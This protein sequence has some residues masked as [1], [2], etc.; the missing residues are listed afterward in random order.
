MIE[1]DISPAA[2]VMA[3]CTVRAKLSTMGVIRGMAGKAIG[4]C[5]SIA[6]CM[7]CLAVDACMLA[8]QR[9]TGEL[10]VI[11]VHVPPAARVMAFS[12]IPAKLTRMLVI[13]LMTGKT[14]HGCAAITV[15]MTAFALDTDMLPCQLESGKSVIE[16]PFCPGS[17]IMAGR[18][19]RSKAHVVEI[20]LLMARITI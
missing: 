14:I 3:G 11:E 16:N 7:A 5:A 20:I 18:A 15:R 6:I 12:T 10:S 13:F 1:G 2:G 4:W 19:F 17:G 9:K 8:C